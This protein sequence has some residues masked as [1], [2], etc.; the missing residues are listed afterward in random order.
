MHEFD[1]I[2]QFK[3]VQNID[4][5]L[6]VLLVAS[7]KLTTDYLS[8]L[9]YEYKQRLGDIEIRLTEVEYIDRSRTTGKIK[10][11][12]SMLYKST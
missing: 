1:K 8:K 9:F 5:S 3:V 2:N 6:D 12:E 10:V 4:Y 11:I 7:E